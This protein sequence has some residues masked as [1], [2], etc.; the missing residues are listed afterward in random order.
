MRHLE[1]LA[2]PTGD[3]DEPFDLWVTTSSI[4]RLGDGGRVEYLYHIREK[5]RCAVIMVPNK[6]NRA[7]QTI[8]KIE[9]LFLDDLVSMCQ[10]AGLWVREAGYLDLPPFPPGI[11]RSVKAKE[12][13]AQSGFERL[14]MR[15]LEW[16]AWGERLWPRFVKRRFGHIAYAVVCCPSP[17]A[18]PGV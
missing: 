17:N 12:N 3:K 11:T 8:T 1:T 4:Q 15:V 9:G 5:T 16:V 2:Q 7:H 18:L 6:H 10:R 14:A 13:A